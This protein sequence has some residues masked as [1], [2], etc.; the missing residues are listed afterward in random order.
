ME[1]DRSTAYVAGAIDTL[2]ALLIQVVILL[3]PKA[4]QVVDE[5]ATQLADW[6][7]VHTDTDWTAGVHDVV[8]R[9]RN[10]ID[11]QLQELREGTRRQF[12][13]PFTAPGRA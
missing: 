3:P 11:M 9:L 12:I 6:A 7:D 4:Q 5:H 1:I 10:D 2:Q 8:T 13:Q